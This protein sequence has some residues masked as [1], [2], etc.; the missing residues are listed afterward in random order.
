MFWVLRSTRASSMRPDVDWYTGTVCIK[1]RFLTRRSGGVI[2][3]LLSCVSRA[4]A[5][6]RL[7]HLRISIPASGAPPGRV[8]ADCYP[9]GAPWK[10]RPSS[11]RVPF[12]DDVTVLG[13]VSPSVCSPLLEK[14]TPIVSAVVVDDVVVPEGETNCSSDVAPDVIP[15]P[16]GFPPFSW[17]IIVG[18]VAIEHRQVFRSAMVVHR[19]FLQAHRMWSRRSRSLSVRWTLDYWCFR[20]WMLV[21]IRRWMSVDQFLLCHPSKASSCRI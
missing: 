8:P 20:W 18:H 21:R 7:T 14:P 3:R 5:I 11:Q 4:M 13:D 9:G 6:T 16:P 1:I 2:P 12:A 15:P 19:T 17:P 10:N